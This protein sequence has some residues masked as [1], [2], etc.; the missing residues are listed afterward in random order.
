ML[1]RVLPFHRRHDVDLTESNTVLRR[2]LQLLRMQIV[3][4]NI[5]INTD[6]NGPSEAVWSKQLAPEEVHESHWAYQSLSPF[7]QP[8]NVALLEG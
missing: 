1:V 6:V 8:S 7:F 2:P 3:Q 5:D 4:R